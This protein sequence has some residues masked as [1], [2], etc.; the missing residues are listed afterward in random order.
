MT[1]TSERAAIALAAQAATVTRFAPSPSGNL[2]LGNA[3]TAL[4]SFLLARRLGGR[5][6]LRIEDTDATRSSEEF[7]RNQ[8]EDLTWL[9]LTW[10]AG[11]G[12]EDGRGPYRQSQ[13]VASYAEHFATL[14]RADRVYECYC[15]ALELE[16]SRKSQIAAGKPP[17]YAGTCRDLS[18][19]Q[20][21]ARRA[22]A[23][24]QNAPAP[25]PDAPA[26][27]HGPSRP[28][29]AACCRGWNARG[30]TGDCTTRR[31]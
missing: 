8:Q 29:P 21:A 11:P 16:V 28:D 9:G 27:R 18:P 17:R 12:R 22:A 13:R 24:R 14:E 1:E 2:H 6:I 7:C 31:R 26:R 19:A 10:D 23:P 3:R 15:T 5:F 4:F 30:G 20:R 25:D